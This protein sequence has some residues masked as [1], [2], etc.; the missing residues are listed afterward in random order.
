M[1][2]IPSHLCRVHSLQIRRGPQTGF[3]I[4][5]PVA[6]MSH[7]RQAIAKISG[8]QF[9]LSLNISDKEAHEMQTQCSCS[10]IASQVRQWRFGPLAPR[11]RSA[12]GFQNSEQ[13]RCWRPSGG[14]GSTLV[15][16]HY[17]RE[18]AARQALPVTSSGSL[19]GSTMARLHY[20]RERAARQA[21]PFTKS[22][23]LFRII[24]PRSFSCVSSPR[25]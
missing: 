9:A 11:T 7:T 2:S 17:I 23:S 21:M 3:A 16:L 14:L 22:G 20:I 1:A 15:P 12:H 6:K 13:Q 19:L 18:W 10:C 4:T 25:A 8:K 24:A 5:L